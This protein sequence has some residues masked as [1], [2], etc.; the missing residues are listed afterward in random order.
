LR[1]DA[2]VLFATLE[3]RRPERIDSI[4]DAAWDVMVD[5]WKHSPEERPQ[6][7]TLIKRLEKFVD[8]SAMYFQASDWL[9]STLRRRVIR[10]PSPF[11]PL[12]YELEGIFWEEGKFFSNPLLGSVPKKRDRE[13]DDDNDSSYG[14]FDYKSYSRK[15]TALSLRR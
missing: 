14:L 3:G 15:A 5:C 9:D 12:G 6:T 11:S 8:L 4:P 13:L 1:N 10:Q 2:L 7:S